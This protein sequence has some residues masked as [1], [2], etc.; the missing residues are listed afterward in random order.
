MYRYR[1]RERERDREM[2]ISIYIYI[3]IHKGPP[4]YELRRPYLALFSKML[5]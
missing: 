3:Y 1:E 2:H 4:H 5:I